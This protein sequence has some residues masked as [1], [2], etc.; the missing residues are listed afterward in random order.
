VCLKN[1]TCSATRFV[2]AW[3]SCAAFGEA[4]GPAGEAEEG[5]GVAAFLFVVEAEPI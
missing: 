1:R 3:L 5:G 4:G 2:V